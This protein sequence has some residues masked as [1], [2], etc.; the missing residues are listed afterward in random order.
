MPAAKWS[1]VCVECGPSESPC[2]HWEPSEEDAIR[3]LS[4]VLGK[5][6]HNLAD[7]QIVRDDFEASDRASKYLEEEYVKLKQ[8]N[9]RL[10]LELLKDGT[11][12]EEEKQE[13]E[14][15]E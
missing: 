14:N 12:F 1:F 7:L 8:E 11:A 4:I 6:K 10:K 13:A 9:A 2:K 5:A 3:L 15:K